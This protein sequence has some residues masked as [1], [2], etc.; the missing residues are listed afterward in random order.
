MI[1]I[2]SIRALKDNYIWCLHDH[3]HAWIID[4]GEANPALSFLKEKNLI[5][6]G[7]FLTHHH[8]DHVNGVEKLL[9]HFSVPVWGSVSFDLPI[10]SNK[11]KNDDLITLEQFHFKVLEIPGHTLD[12]IALYTGAELFCGDTLFGAGCGRLFEGTPEQMFESLQK[13]LKLPLHTKIYC[14]HEYT[15]IN[16]KFA[17]TVEPDNKKI[18]QR[19]EQV[20]QRYQQNLSSVPS[21]LAEERE[22]NPF[23]RCDIAT[24][25]KA[26]EQYCNH[27]LSNSLEV[28]TQIRR[29]K[30][31]FTF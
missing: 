5:L 30:D 29:W 8:W 9:E 26:A 22:T 6:K 14:A 12:H 19:I 31:N 11:I 10:I 21:T 24:V 3:Q 1:N 4:P 27:H 23:L 16:L 2:S 7:I 25:K 28:F 13:I 15:L 18:Q 20:K 17:E